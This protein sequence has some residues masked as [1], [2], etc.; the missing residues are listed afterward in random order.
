MVGGCL[1]DGTTIV[2]VRS[3]KHDSVE[4]KARRW[5]RWGSLVEMERG[6]ERERY[7]LKCIVGNWC[8]D[9]SS[10]FSHEMT[11]CTVYCT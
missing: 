2:E 9:A 1:G 7:F 8:I 10:Y 4:V 11:Q 6:C 3:L 5:Q